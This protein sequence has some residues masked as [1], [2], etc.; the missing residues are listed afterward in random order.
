M[1]NG[2]SHFISKLLPSGYLHFELGPDVR[3][4][5]IFDQMEV[6]KE[7]LS[8]EDYAVNQTSLEQVLP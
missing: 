8:I 1:A 5:T 7:G 2:D 3:W 4:S 6:N